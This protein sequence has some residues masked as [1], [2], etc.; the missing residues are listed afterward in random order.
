MKE[1]NTTGTCIP[2]MHY[3]VDT[4]AKLDQITGLIDRGKYFTINRPRQY[5]KT[6]TLYLLERRLSGKYVVI[7]TSFEGI[8][9]ERFNSEK[10]FAEV[11]LLLIKKEFNYS[12][13]RLLA[14]FVDQNKDIGTLD[15]LSDFISRL[16]SLAEKKILLMIDEVDKSSNNQLFLSFLGMLRNKYL[17]RNEGKDCTF[18]SVIL[19]GVHD[20]KNL[21]LKLRPDE[22]RKYNSPWNIAVDLKVDL[23]FSPEEIATML[24]DYAR[25]KNLAMDIK[26][27]SERIHYHTSGYPFLV[28][29]ICEI[30]DTELTVSRRWEIDDVDAAVKMLLKE[31][32]PNFESLVKNLENNKELFAMVQSIII[33]GD[34]V[35]F[36]VDNPVVYS[37]VLFG[38][39]KDVHGKTQIGNR[40][41][42][43]RIY[44]YMA[45]K[46]ETSYVMGKREYDPYASGNGLDMEKL[47]LKF[48]QFMKE[49][50][51]SRDEEFLERHGKLLFLAFIKPVINGKG[52]DFKEAQISEEKRL[53][54]VITY[55][56]FKYL[57][58]LKIWRGSEYHKKGL[59]QLTDYLDREDLD[60]GYLVVFDPKKSLEVKWKQEKLVAG[61]RDI[62]IVFV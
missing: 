59:M 30:I 2:E 14:D 26:Q 32:N 33:D 51:S 25:E 42:E 62:F 55:M 23:S 39:F 1:F 56:N 3:M 12:G 58:E 44:N 54:V 19:A 24:S 17:L 27:I 21:K 6:T 10:G 35:G 18:Y 7:R 11:F 22:E 15:V 13:N 34:N 47:L 9:D 36:N 5:G 28:S 38:V 41:Y 29:R 40:I 4:S 16:C 8:G 50:F 61:G 45:S 60:K 37:G 52:F 49:N 20:V 53:D 43:Q 31:S 48:Q 57:V 46:I